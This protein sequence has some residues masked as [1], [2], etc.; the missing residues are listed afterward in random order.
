MHNHIKKQVEN[1]QNISNKLY[2]FKLVSIVMTCRAN[3]LTYKL[4]EVLQNKN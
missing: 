3:A 1:I 4:C 2:I